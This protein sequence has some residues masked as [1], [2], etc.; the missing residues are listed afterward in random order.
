MFKR[1][2]MAISDWRLVKRKLIVG[3]AISH[4]RDGRQVGRLA[5]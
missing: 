5:K 4:D 3:A 2:R 1:Q